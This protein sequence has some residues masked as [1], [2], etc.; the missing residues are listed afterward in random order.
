MNTEDKRFTIFIAVLALIGLGSL[1]YSYITRPEPIPKELKASLKTQKEEIQHHEKALIDL[2]TK[3]DR[4]Y[5]HSSDLSDDQL[6]DW[7]ND[8]L[9]SRRQDSTKQDHHGETGPE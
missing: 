8:W 6:V 9:R 1:F 5:P 7:Y 3:I 4:N 2:R